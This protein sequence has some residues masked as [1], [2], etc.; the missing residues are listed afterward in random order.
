M[1]GMCPVTAHERASHSYRGPLSQEV[2]Y[3]VISLLWGLRGTASAAEGT[4]LS[5]LMPHSRTSTDVNIYEQEYM[6][7]SNEKITM[8]GN[9]LTV[10]GRCIEEGAP[11]PAFKLTAA[12]LSDV[13]NATYAGKVL[14]LM[15]IP[16]ID[17]PVCAIETKKFNQEAVG[18][19]QDVVIASVSRDLPFALKRWC[20]AEGVDRVVTLSDHKHRG[21][22]KEYGVELPD[23]GLLA[24]ALFV[25]DKSGKV[26]HVEYVS[27][28]AE[29]PDYAAALSA[30]KD[31]L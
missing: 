31:S 19:S 2:A 28:V 30:I 12:D 24:R 13:T 14:V 15:S 7:K 10:E 18:L 22:G 23:L 26:V 11:A 17:T 27:E 3:H 6:A 21:F 16:S 4:Q 5:M 9:P 1:I 25:V 8:K 20:A 29:E